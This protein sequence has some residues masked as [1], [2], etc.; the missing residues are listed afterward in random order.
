MGGARC[1]RKAGIMIRPK[2]HDIDLINRHAPRPGRGLDALIP[3]APP[4]DPGVVRRVQWRQLEAALF[5]LTNAQFEYERGE[6]EDGR[7]HVED[8]RRALGALALSLADAPDAEGYAR[9]FEAITTEPKVR[10]R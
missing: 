8:C 6:V 7:T 2:F 9:L 5:S 4:A 1:R 10:K 3:T